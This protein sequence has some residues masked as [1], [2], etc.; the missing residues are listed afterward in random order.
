VKVKAGLDSAPQWVLVSECNI[1]VWPFDLRALPGQSRPLSLRAP[2]AGDLPSN[3]GPVCRTLPRKTNHVGKPHR[4][5]N[6]V[7]ASLGK[8]V[9]RAT[10]EFQKHMGD[11]VEWEWGLPANTRRA[12]LTVAAL[13]PNANHDGGAS[14]CRPRSLSARWAESRSGRSGAARRRGL[15][16]WRR[17]PLLDDGGWIV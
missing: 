7:V 11:A 10:G 6:P 4:R 15:R 13:P 9:H 14:R 12:W 8:S 3:P 2:A 1:D 5:I 16:P 17:P